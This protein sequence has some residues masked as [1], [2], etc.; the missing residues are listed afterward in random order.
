MSDYLFHVDPKS[1]A[2]AGDEHAIQTRLIGRLKI[3]APRV[4]VIAIP[5]QGQRSAYTS[6]K[7]KSEG[8][9]KGAWDLLMQWEGPHSAWLEM[10]DRDGSLKIEQIEFGNRKVREGFPCG[11]FRSVDTAVAFLRACDAPFLSL[12]VAA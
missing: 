5:N 6:M 3:I 9:R 2:D 7:M 4:D 8:L 10:K 1:V 12:E 11:V